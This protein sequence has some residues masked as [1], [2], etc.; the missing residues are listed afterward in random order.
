MIIPFIFIIS[1]NFSSFSKTITYINIGSNKDK[2]N[3]YKEAEV[4]FI[5]YNI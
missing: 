3:G 4:I 5:I 1:N 2:A